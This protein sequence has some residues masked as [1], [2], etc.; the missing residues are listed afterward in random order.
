MMVN[1]LNTNVTFIA[2]CTPGRTINETLVAKFDCNAVRFYYLSVLSMN[3]S[4]LTVDLVEEG[5]VK[6]YFLFLELVVTK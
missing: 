6:G 4:V 2:V 3:Y 5:K 1:F